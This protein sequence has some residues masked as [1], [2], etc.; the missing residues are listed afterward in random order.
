MKSIIIVLL[1]AIT[2]AGSASASFNEQK[3]N[4]KTL[5][6]SSSNL[7][8]VIIDTY[9]ET[10]PDSPKIEAKLGIIWNGDGHPNSVTDS[11][12]NYDGDIR[13]ELRGATS[14]GFP[15]KQYAFETVDSL[16]ENNNVSLLG[17]PKENDWILHAPYSDKSLMRNVLEYRLAR[18]LGWYA[19]RTKY[20]E[21]ILNGDYRGV[22][23]LMEKIK[24]DKNR[25]DIATLNPEEISGD[26][27]T[28]GYII[29]IDKTEGEDNGGWRSDYP[30]NADLVER[31]FYQYHY[32]K[33]S[34][35]VEE[36]K[37]YIKGFISEFES[38]MDSESYTDTLT[39]YSKYINTE[40]FIDFLILNEIGRNV[41]GY[42]LSTFLHKDK[43]SN[44]GKLKMGPV[45]DFNLAFGNVTYDDGFSTAGWYVLSPKNLTNN[46]PFWWRKLLEDKSFISKLERRWFEL[47]EI[48]LA[49][50]RIVYIIDSLA[51]ELQEAQIRNF[52]RWD[53]LGTYIWPNYFIGATHEEE[54]T[55]LK[56]W[57][58]DRMAWMDKNIAFDYFGE[59]IADKG[60]YA[61]SFDGV[62]DYVDCGNDSTL[63]IT[64]KNIT[65]EAWVNVNEFRD[66]SFKGAIISRDQMVAGADYG[67]VLRCGG[68]GYLDFIFGNGHWIGLQSPPDAITRDVWTHLA[69]TYDGTKMKLYVNGKIVSEKAVTTTFKASPSIN[70]FIGNSPADRTRGFD[71]TIDEV[72][73]WNKTRSENQIVSTMNISLDQVYYVSADS[74]LVG[75][76]RLDEGVSGRTKDRTNVNHG[77]LGAIDNGDQSEPVWVASSLP[78]AIDGSEVS[79]ISGYKLNQNYPNPFNPATIIQYQI[80]VSERVRL[81][82]YDILGRDVVTLVDN[83]MSAGMHQVE[84][85]ASDLSS[86][87]YFY[88]IHTGAFSDM[89]K[90]I[91]LK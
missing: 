49:D 89:K 42:R 63:A 19:S 71:G 15:K 17:M 31:I 40:S 16:G 86:G 36:Q 1:C 41:D 11:L 90:L 60:E 29:K 27:V 58:I 26:D 8:I 35:I 80:P 22:Y 47:R 69:A 2:F 70:L 50:T 20:C 23:V 45:W 73:V 57:V 39:G 18:D 5:A 28:G 53:I 3:L 59:I 81:I 68:T 33:F 48:Q 24:R 88:Q 82:V 51:T 77:F 34:D 46:I 72:R 76:W 4:D 37:E 67:Y 75:Y 25:V 52:E 61:L 32:P 78:L 10:I 21:L 84:F 30:A 44:G 62:D 56:D 14:Q 13:I 9:G 6:F 7:P 55:Y 43:A 83:Q 38:V 64:G 66:E 74:G 91:L 85:D 12:N 65:L 87:I 79:V 54:I